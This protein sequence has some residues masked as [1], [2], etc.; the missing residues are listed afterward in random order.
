MP[1]C[2]RRLPS[3]LSLVIPLGPPFSHPSP[4]L[5]C[6]AYAP[7]HLDRPQVVD[8]CVLGDKVVEDEVAKVFK[9]KQFEKG[10]AFP[11]CVS[12][13]SVI[14]HFSPLSDDTTVIAAED[15]VKV[16]L[17]AHINGFIATVATTVVAGVESVTGR[18]ADVIAAASQCFEAALR[19]I[20]PGKKGS[21][22]S[23]VLEKVASVSRTGGEEGRFS[24]CWR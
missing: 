8:L 16:D 24:S 17:G 12:I 2:A 14:G 23:D 9:S 10:I 7:L 20:R 6:P 18:K 21:D 22:V 4:S 3:L 13:N 11:T 5:P 15:V 19:S 1:A